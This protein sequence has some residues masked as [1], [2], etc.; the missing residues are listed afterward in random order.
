MLIPSALIQASAARARRSGILD[1]AAAPPPL[2][3]ELSPAQ[4]AS[5]FATVMAQT[6][7][8]ETTER[9]LER[10]IGGND[11]VGIA[12]LERGTLC[13]RSICRVR[14]RD[15]AGNTVG[16][17]TGFLIAPGV[18][19]TNH[20]VIGSP[21]EAGTA[22]AEFDYQRDVRG[23]DLPVATFPVLAEPAP[24]T[25]EAL[26]FTLAAVGPRA[27]DG[28]DLEPFGFLP[29]DGTPG[30]AAVGEYLTI[31]Q[32]PSGERKQVCV[33]ENRV[34]RYDE[35]GDTVWYETDT[36]AG[37]SGSPAFND[38]WQVVA[39]HHSGVP[40]TDAKGHW[41]TVDGTPWDASMDE[42]RVAWIAN[43][44]I[45]VS[46]IVEHLRT[47]AAGHPLAQRVLQHVDVAVSSLVAHPPIEV[48]PRAAGAALALGPGAAANGELRFTVPVEVALRVGLPAGWSVNAAALP[49][50]ATRIAPSVLPAASPAAN[51]G[52]P[53]TSGAARRSPR[54]PRLALGAGV[55]RVDVDQSNYAERPGYDPGFLGRGVEVPLPRV[56]D[57]AFAGQVLAFKEQGEMTSVLRYWNYSVVM[58]G[59]RR[60]AFFSAVNVDPSLRPAGA[61]RDGDRW[62][63]D[64]RIPAD[65]QLGAEFYGQQT[66]FEDRA[67]SPFDRG[68]LTRRLDAQWGEGADASRNGNDSFH[69]TNCS[70][71][72]WQYNQGTKRWLGLEDYVIKGFA[73]AGRACVINGPVFDA[74]RTQRGDG[75]RL[76]PVLDPA[77]RVAD[78]TFGGVA[79]PKAFFKVV[80]CAVGGRLS[81]AGFLMSQED[82]LLET[83]RVVGL[84]EL[85][86]REAQVYQ[87]PL[88]ALARLTGLDLGP[89]AQA[90]RLL[91]GA[92]P[93]E[94]RRLDGLEDVELGRARTV[95][96]RSG[97]KAL[98]LTAAARTVTRRTPRRGG[99]KATARRR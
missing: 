90:E 88:A 74:P 84:E 78:P 91:G 83:G 59:A 31:V 5:R 14:L 50:G 13:A 48:A 39:L 65:R 85:S 95:L 52:A 93:T 98:P 63:V 46:R 44:G 18:L 22:Q 94:A 56:V 67:L 15:G 11:L 49:A 23:A 20:H 29:L 86:E 19:L 72:H 8:A 61:G 53:G 76:I 64:P 47:A 3:R 55:E 6:G 17:G 38:A 57:R 10:L 33:R 30:K 36:T 4:R 42:S 79:I 68:H 45:R 71:Q 12:T 24:L 16:F 27:E 1:R 43:E 51:G 69:F 92:A 75:G 58:N 25:V 77:A 73:G 81:A 7:S 21:A 40:K 80:A 2:R 99:A 37:S 70:P 26:D 96:R 28:R 41:L 89:L 66:T 35:G 62:Y 34:L 87:V 32:H 82:L 97:K 60:L 9:T 54:P